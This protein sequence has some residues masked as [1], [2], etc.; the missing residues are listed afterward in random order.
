MAVGIDNVTITI[1]VRRLK[2]GHLRST[3]ENSYGRVWMDSGATVRR[4]PVVTRWLKMGMWELN[5]D[6]KHLKYTT[7]SG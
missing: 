6:N 4:L 3:L 5:G 7:G 1:I 2:V